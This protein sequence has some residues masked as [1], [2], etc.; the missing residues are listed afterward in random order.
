MLIGIDG[1][2]ASVSRRVGV[3]RLAVEVIRHLEKIDK[4]NSYRI[5]VPGN[6]QP[7]M[8]K[9]KQRW[10]Y[11]RVVHTRL[12]SQL[13]LPIHLMLDRPTPDVFLSPVHYAP[14]FCPCPSVIFVFDLS[15]IHFPELFKESDS[16][17]LKN[18][19][20]Y[21]VEKAA[22]MLTISEASKADIIEQYNVDS[23]KVVVAYPG[24]RMKV[25]KQG[26]RV[27]SILKRY[28]IEEDYILYVGTLQP[29]KNLV[30]LIE[31][32]KLAMEQRNNG[33]MNLVIVGKKG[34]MYE[35]IFA[36]V[37]EL[38]L[39]QK[40][41]FTDFVPDE[42][43]QALY[44]RAKCL[45]L[46]SL[47]EGFGLP[48]VEAMAY[49]VP[50]VVSNTSSL[51]EIVGGVGIM[52]N[53]DQTEDIANGILEVLGMSES[54]YKEISDR[55]KRQARKFS[56]EKTARETLKVLEEVASGK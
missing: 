16:Y 26:S 4:K 46:V 5:Y 24:I 17:K 38:N 13:T 12:W 18:W 54:E 47:Y 34:W 22:R 53:P 27:K 9:E 51:P 23:N 35:E 39:E 37:K 28:G 44:S 15:Y 50:V 48:V 42:E 45:V 25:K 40:V 10:K 41:I 43:L 8:P 1:F 19:T 31:A 36:K 7:G 11:R 32:F 29:R 33:T 21:S 20:K 52:V 3:G 30:R 6:V 14:R 55:C 56:W 49:G 2:E